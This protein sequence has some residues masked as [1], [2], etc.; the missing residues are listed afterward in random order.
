L[1]KAVAQAY[2][3]ARSE[4]LEEAVVLLSPACASFDQFRNFEHRGDVFANCVRQLADYQTS[5]K[6]SK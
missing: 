3:A 4:G 1:E 2:Q 5:A 6:G